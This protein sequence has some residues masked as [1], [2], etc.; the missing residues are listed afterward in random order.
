MSDTTKTGTPVQTICKPIKP[1]GTYIKPTFSFPVPLLNNFS[2]GPKIPNPEVP[3]PELQ[4]PLVKVTH[5]RDFLSVDTIV[6][7]DASVKFDC[8]TFSP[9][10]KYNNEENKLII[11]ISYNSDP[12][13]S[14]LCNAY[15]I[16]IIFL[17][18]P[19]VPINT[20]ETYLWDD[21]PETSRGTVTTVPNT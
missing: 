10:Y 19:I 18:L 21:D 3:N 17:D 4:E 7:V 6:L 20:V 16:K 13:S 11:N 5:F 12:P 9:Y 15:Y 2:V 8:N 1:P 14:N